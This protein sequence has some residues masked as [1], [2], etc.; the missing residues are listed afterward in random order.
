MLIQNIWSKLLKKLF[1]NEHF[2]SIFYII[3]RN[4]GESGI[5]SRLVRHLQRYIVQRVINIIFIYY[6]GS[7]HKNFFQELSE[8]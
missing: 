1:E 7:L 3:I 6:A 5:K 2:C 4:W 8:Q